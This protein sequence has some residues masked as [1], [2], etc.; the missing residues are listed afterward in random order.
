VKYRFVGRNMLLVDRDNN[1]I[2][3]YMLNALP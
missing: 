3:D 2:I 1:L